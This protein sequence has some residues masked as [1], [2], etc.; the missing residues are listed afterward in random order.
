MSEANLPVSNGVDRVPELADP[1][2]DSDPIGRRIA[3]HV[4]VETNPV[5]R[6]DEAVLFICIGGGKLSRLLGEG[7][8]HQVDGMTL[9]PEPFPTLLIGQVG[10]AKRT[11][12][13]RR[14]H[15]TM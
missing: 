14:K 3:G 8:L 5:D 6:C 2:T 4:A 12:V 9:A 15:R 11:N 13:L 1:V 10:V 7:K